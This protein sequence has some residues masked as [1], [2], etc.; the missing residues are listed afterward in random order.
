MFFILSKILFFLLVPFYWIVILLIWRWICKTPKLKKRLLVLAVLIAVLFTNPYLYRSLMMAWQ[1]APV[2]LAPG[3]KYEAG[4]VLGGM[5]GY[6]KNGRGYFGEN[7]DRFIQ[8]AN[9]YHMGFIKKIVIS[10][11]SGLLF[12][13]GLAES[14]FLKAQFL[15]NGINDSDIIIESNSRNTFENAVYS[16]EITDSLHLQPPF[17]L[18][19]SAMHMKR[20]E[21]VFK[22][23]NL[24]CVSFPCDYKVNAE[25]FSVEDYIIPNISLLNKWAFLLK[26]IVGLYVYKLTGKA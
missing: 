14:F 16:K 22:K 5:S 24:A 6:D 17:I 11:G 1:P 8:T 23:A 18:I 2:T 21:N 13:D 26:E 9:L 10:G 25:E 7:A 12:Q 15:S 3:K 19:T 20:S 4:I